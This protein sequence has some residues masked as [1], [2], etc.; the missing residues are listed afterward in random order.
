MNLQKGNLLY[1]REAGRIR[2]L[3][4]VATV[5]FAAWIFWALLLKFSS[6][7]G[8]SIIYKRMRK[9]TLEERFL[10]EIIPFWLGDDYLNRTLLVIAN[11]LVFAPFGVLLQYSF[12]EKNIWRDVGICFSISFCIEATQLITLL[13]GFATTD[14]I[15]NT[16][17][18]FIGLWIYRRCFANAQPHKVVRFYRIF[19][20]LM[21]CLL[22]FAVLV[23]YYNRGAIIAILTRTL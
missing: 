5:L 9:M 12:R 11:G 3:A 4:A 14:L 17:G 8:L 20:A 15:M 23:T 13:G 7:Q 19:N 22:L 10:S 21:V 18:Y 6:A 2:R 16:F 1:Q